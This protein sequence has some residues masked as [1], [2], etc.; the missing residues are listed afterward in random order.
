MSAE[1]H[2]DV[3][4]RAIEAVGRGDGDALDALLAPDMTDHNPMPG[5]P[6]G[7]EGFKH[8]M[9]SVRTS[10]PGLTGSVEDVVAEGDRVAGRITWAGTHRGTFAG[11]AA[12]GKPVRFTAI[13]IV[14]LA[15]GRIAEWW[16]AASLL[17]ALEQIGARS[18]TRRSA[19]I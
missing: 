16:G 6:P 4:R 3:Y 13:H 10:L 5:Q 9:R 7:R 19:S 2:R 1:K 17:D 15:D 11:V 18:G 8:W 12:T 14:R